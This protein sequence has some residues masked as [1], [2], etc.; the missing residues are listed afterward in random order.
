MLLAIIIEFYSTT[1]SSVYGT[2]I[3]KKISGENKKNPPA[4]ADGFY[5]FTGQYLRQK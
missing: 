2:F 4:Y 1:S 5:K 3:T